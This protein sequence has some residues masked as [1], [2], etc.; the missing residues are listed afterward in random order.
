MPRTALVRH[1]AL[2]LTCL[3]GALPAQAP[4]AADAPPTRTL[5]HAGQLI[6]GLADRPRE[7]QGI[8]IPGEPIVRIG[9]WAEL[10]ALAG[11]ARTVDLSRMTVLPGLIDNHTHILLQR[12]ITAADYDDQ[13]LKESIP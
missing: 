3:G 10:S 11:G 2:A 4:G 8:L 9:P 7:D 6:D 5:V 12:D 13:L 1:G